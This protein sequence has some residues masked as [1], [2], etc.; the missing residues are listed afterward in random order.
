MPQFTL[1]NIK[2]H[3]LGRNETGAVKEPAN[4]YNGNSE[5]MFE[6]NFRRLLQPWTLED[7]KL[8]CEDCGVESEGV[9]SR[10]FEVKVP[11]PYLPGEFMNETEYHDL[12]LKCSEKR[13]VT[14]AILADKIHLAICEI[15]SCPTLTLSMFVAS[16]SQIPW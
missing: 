9:F 8:K 15:P 13:S 10:S 11:F 6:R 12:C 1:L 4:V 7:L 14:E 5:V 16:S 3:I 2:A